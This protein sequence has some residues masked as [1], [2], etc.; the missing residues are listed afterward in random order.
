YTCLVCN[1]FDDE[2]RNQYHCD[3]CGICRVG[4]RGRF[5]H[6]EVCNMCLP[7]QLKFDGHRLSSGHYACPTC[8]TSMMDMNQ[9]WEYLDAEV[10]ATPMPKEYANYFVDIL[11]K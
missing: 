9:L 5:F 4:G 3:G 1:L 8:Q 2:D 6:C 11:C 10:A 7:L